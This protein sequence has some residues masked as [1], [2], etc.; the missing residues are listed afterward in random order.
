MPRIIK[1][2]TAAGVNINDVIIIGINREKKQP[3]EWIDKFFNIFQNQNVNLFLPTI[4]IS[5][6]NTQWNY[7]KAETSDFPDWQNNIYLVLKN[8]DNDISE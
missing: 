3:E 2:L 6:A 8:F 4:L 5:K 7:V 1:F